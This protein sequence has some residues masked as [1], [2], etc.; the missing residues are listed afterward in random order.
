MNSMAQKLSS[1][2]QS[3]ESGR[4][5]MVTGSYIQDQMTMQADCNWRPDPKVGGESCAVADI[6][7]HPFDIVQ[8][9]TGKRSVAVNFSMVTVYDKRLKCAFFFKLSRCPS[10]AVTV[11]NAAAKIF[12]CQASIYRANYGIARLPEDGTRQDQR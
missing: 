8:Y 6:G 12:L 10:S 3:G 5:L 11:N 4:K 9:V 1:R 2:I 7:S